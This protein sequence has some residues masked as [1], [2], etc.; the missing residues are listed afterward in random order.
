MA[1]VILCKTQ[2]ATLKL[3]HT[4]PLPSSRNLHSQ[5]LHISTTDSTLHTSQTP[6]PL[7]YHEWEHNNQR[8]TCAALRS[9]RGMA[10]K[11]SSA[12]PLVN[13][14]RPILLYTVERAM[15]LRTS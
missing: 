4:V 15:G 13:L 8:Q 1:Q 7:H 5:R 11:I 2:I 6:Y 14:I 3:T 12:L 10:A 9:N